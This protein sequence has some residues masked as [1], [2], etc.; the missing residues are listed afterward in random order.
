MNRVQQFL[1][2]LLLASPGLLWGAD[3]SPR[4]PQELLRQGSEQLVAGEVEAS[5]QTL[6]S[7]IAQKPDAKPHLWQLGIAYYYTGRF[8]DGRD[9]FKAHQ[10]V[11]SADVE[12][13]VWHFLCIARIDGVET[14]RKKLI[15]ITG[16]TRV[17]M[18][19]VHE[20]FAGTG[21][22]EN[23]LSAASKLP[24][25]RERKN[26]LCYAHLYLALYYEALNDRTRSSVHIEKAASEFKQDHYMG[27]IAAL[28][29]KLRIKQ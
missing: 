2:L 20:L 5:I 11:N 24:S 3:A 12:N 23:V 15:P 9:L 6:E 22:T 25:D 28:H 4:P 26:A 7:L 10:T 29:K 13:A 14:A 8:A 17:P 19:E 18:K 27:K 21:T 16:D 1:L